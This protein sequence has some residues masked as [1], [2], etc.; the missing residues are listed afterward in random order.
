MTDKPLLFLDV[1]GVFNRFALQ[2]VNTPGYLRHTID[3]P[4]FPEP[5]PL[6]LDGADTARVGAM[7]AVAEPVWA[8]TWN[9]HANERMAP[10]I[11]LAP[12]PVA[13][14]NRRFS[15]H[16][17]TA[18]WKWRYV[19]EYAAGRP[20][21]WIDDGFTRQM[22]TDAQRRSRWAGIQCTLIMA[23][24]AVGLTDEMVDSVRLF[25]DVVAGAGRTP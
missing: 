9:H 20:F 24:P 5:V 14:M 1:D 6:V 18:Q 16:D 4:G 2:G 13:T 25:A 3:L 15:E 8:T 7:A 11:G 23:D 10:L 21:A 12:L 19:M 17:N 22:L